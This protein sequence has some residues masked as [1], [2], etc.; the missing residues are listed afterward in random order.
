MA[1]ICRILRRNTYEPITNLKDTNDTFH[2]NPEEIPKIFANHQFNITR[3]RSN[4]IDEDA[5]YN[6]EIIRFEISTE[7]K[8]IRNSTLDLDSMDV[9]LLKKLTT[10]HVDQ[11]T[12]F[13]NKIWNGSELPQ[14]L[15]ISARIT[16]K[17]T[18]QKQI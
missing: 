4:I 3:N 10:F 5:K 12:K 6:S 8:G 11:L 16:D 15:E 14:G 9:E 13:M 2:T 7:N 17:K 1:Q 18:N